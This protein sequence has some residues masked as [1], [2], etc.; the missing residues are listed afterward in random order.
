MDGEQ[1]LTYFTRC[2]PQLGYR[3]STLKLHLASI[4]FLY[5]EVLNKQVHFDFNIKMK[6]PATIPEVL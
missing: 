6:K 5:Q 4:K 1:L 2:K 3:Y